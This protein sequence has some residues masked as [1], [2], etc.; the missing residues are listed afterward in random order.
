ME[1]QI[2]RIFAEICYSAKKLTTHRQGNP[3]KVLCAMPT[4]LR[5]DAFGWEDGVFQSDM[6]TQ[7][8]GHATHH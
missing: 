1:T 4:T 5:G 7:S 8:S 3:F 2:S 6:A